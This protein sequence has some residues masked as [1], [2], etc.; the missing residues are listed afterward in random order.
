MTQQRK[1][2][3]ERKES[4][5]VVAI[6]QAQKP[7]GLQKLSRVE[8]ANEVG[9][10]RSLINYYFEG[11]EGLRKAVIERAVK[12]TNFAIIAQAVANK[13]RAVSRLPTAVKQQA[14]ATLHA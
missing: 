9:C 2:Y 11:T 3:D 14:L 10:N 5:L 7:G 1:T 13:D 8:V 12:T 4:I 6:K